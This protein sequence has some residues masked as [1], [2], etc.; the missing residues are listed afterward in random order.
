M[1]W[2]VGE[3]DDVY[4]ST[5]TQEHSTVSRGQSKPDRFLF[6]YLYFFCCCYYLFFI[7]VYMCYIYGKKDKKIKCWKNKSAT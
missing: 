3:M 2:E 1:S 5:I 4:A 7:S 6:I